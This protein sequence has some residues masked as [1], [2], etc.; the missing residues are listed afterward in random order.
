MTGLA[1]LLSITPARVQ[2]NYL[3]WRAAAASLPYLGQRAQQIQL[4]FSRAVA[5]RAELPARWR[6]CVST[7]A[8]SLPSAV[9]A[10]YVRKHFSQVARQQAVEMVAEIR[11]QFKW[12]E[13]DP[14]H[15]NITK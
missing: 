1:R 6:R 5:G 12:V 3:A 9:G 7:T 2:G 14:V 13:T 15:L 11:Q 4:Q 8:A 10:L